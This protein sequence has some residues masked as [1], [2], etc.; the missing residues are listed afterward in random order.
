MLFIVWYH[1]LLK[2]IVPVDDAPVYKAMYMP[3]HVAVIC[4][5]LISGYF[6]I[7]PSLRGV[8]K[9][10]FPLFIYY[11]PLTVFEMFV[12]GSFWR[13]QLFF[14]SKS[15]YWFIRVYFYLF[16]VSPVLNSFLVSDRRRFSLLVVLGFV[17]VY[18]GWLMRDHSMY[19]GKNLVLFMFLYVLGDSIRS[20]RKIT[21]S[22][23]NWT[24][25]VLYI[26]LNVFLV[27]SYVTCC[28]S[29]L[30]TIVWKLSFP[31]NSPVLIINSVLLFLIIGRL[32]FKSRVVNWLAGSVFA[33]YILHHQHYVLYYL[34]KPFVMSVYCMI[35]SP[36]VLIMV[37]GMMSLAILM[38][39][40]I[41]DKF[42]LP[43]QN[44]FM[45]NLSKY[46]THIIENVRNRKK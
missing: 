13:G 26:S 42:F 43:V 20:F 22:I 8:A 18:M 38:L 24:I 45:K 32:H 17:A 9:L 37:L 6:H 36:L 41:V 4:F 16:L 40:I 31:Y 5:V 1:L 39:F 30:G 19:D 23:G 3:L 11:L 35:K 21:E 44:A 14:F 28:D 46:E 34:I 25:V 12:D 27:I 10:L 2:F 7:R 29:I 15:P 33:V